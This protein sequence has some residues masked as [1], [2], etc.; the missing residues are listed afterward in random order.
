MLPD[1]AAE[2]Q[3]KFSGGPALLQHL[4]QSRKLASE[5]ARGVFVKEHEAEIREIAVQLG[6]L[7]GKVQVYHDRNG[8]MVLRC[9]DLLEG[10]PE[11]AGGAR[12]EA[13]NVKGTGGQPFPSNCPA[14]RYSALFDPNPVFD[15][16]REAFRHSGIPIRR[17]MLSCVCCSSRM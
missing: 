13:G 11:G 16:I 4:A 8:C 15:A 6:Y 5:A 12:D 1:L 7:S 2:A 9:D 17:P 10:L 3:M 14:C